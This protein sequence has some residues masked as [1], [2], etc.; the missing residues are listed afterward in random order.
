MQLGPWIAAP[1]C[2]KRGT[3]TCRVLA[4]LLKQYARS[5]RGVLAERVLSIPERGRGDHPIYWVLWH[6]NPNG[7]SGEG[8][9]T[10]K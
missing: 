6:N 4:G 9:K 2:G 8:K 7:K 1:V 10:G 3:V 5:V